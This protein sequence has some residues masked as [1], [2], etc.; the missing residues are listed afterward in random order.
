[1]MMTTTGRGSG[2]R[3]HQRST[4]WTIAGLSA[5]VVLSGATGC[6]PEHTNAPGGQSPITS[7]STAAA[8]TPTPPATSPPVS[9]PP[10]RPRPLRKPGR[11]PVRLPDPRKVNFRDPTAVSR[12]ALT[13]MWTVDTTSDTSQYQAE[14]RA[15]PFCTPT[16][17]D[18]LR[19]NPPRSGPGA[20]WNT[21]AAHR[22]Y[23]TAALQPAYDD[24][25]PDTP[26]QALRQWGVITHPVGRDGWHGRPVSA[27]AFVTLTRGGPGQP[28]RVSGVRLSN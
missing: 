23:T 20:D 11:L 24:Q 12:A 2:H 15:A 27:T 26:T 9:S 28:W 13:V 7:P 6:S 21:W 16:Y 14:L 18:Q 5:A 4:Q 8:S 17:T 22:A 3:R 25:P 10:L 1:M 19:R